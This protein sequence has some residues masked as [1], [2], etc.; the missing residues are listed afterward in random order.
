MSQ[1]HLSIFNLNQQLQCAA[2]YGPILGA[3]SSP[4]LLKALIQGGED[5]VWQIEYGNSNGPDY[6]FIHEFF[7]PIIDS[8]REQFHNV[9]IL[10]CCRSSGDLDLL[11]RGLSWKKGKWGIST[12][13]D[14]LQSIKEAKR[15]IVAVNQSSRE[16]G[17]KFHYIGTDEKFYL[18]ILGIAERHT[19]FT[20]KTME[21][22]LKTSKRKSEEI[23]HALDD[24]VHRGQ[25][26][27][28]PPK[29]QSQPRFE[30]SSFSRLYQYQKQK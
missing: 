3:R 26:F 24:L 27:K 19:S 11:I 15:Y 8:I 7:V 25:L 18:Q 14:S 1:G 30:Y 29:N 28:A 21:R 5:R 23:V 6:K 4:K 2:F 20:L 17:T 13:K 10:V 9:H 22:A 12:E 16:N